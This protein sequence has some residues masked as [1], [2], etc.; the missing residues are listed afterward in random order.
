MTKTDSFQLRKAIRH[1]E[2]DYTLLTAALRDYAGI[3]QKIHELLKSGVI[4]RVKKGLYVFA[5][6]YNQTPICKEG[7]ANL[8]YGPS[9]ISLE[10]ALAHHGL[11]PERVQTLTSVTPKRDKEFSTPLGNFTYRYLGSDKYPHGID[12][13]WIDSNHPVL[14][15]SPEKALADFVVL[16]KITG[17]TD[18]DSA[19]NFL[20]SDLR[21]EKEN[22]KQ[23]DPNSLRKLNKFYRNRRIEQ[24]ADVL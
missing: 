7:L 20:E 6:A 9:C 10:Y 17:I 19:Q 8:I 16:N 2:F 13:V 5:P 23:F 3:R 15:A 1:E 24:I 14:M 22:W 21:I 4:V 12:Q 11:I 18:G